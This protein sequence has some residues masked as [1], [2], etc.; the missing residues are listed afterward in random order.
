MEKLYRGPFKILN[1]GIL[2]DIPREKES[3]IPFGFQSESYLIPL[4]YN[5]W[6]PG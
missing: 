4:G 2:K 3:G 1:F 5:F 6:I